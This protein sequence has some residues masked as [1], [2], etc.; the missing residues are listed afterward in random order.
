MQD[1][2]IR[3]LLHEGIAAAKVAQQTPSSTSQIASNQT[4]KLLSDIEEYREQAR[5]L[6]LQVVEQD[7]TNVQA[8]LWL[9]TVV[10]DQNARYTCLSNVLALD[11]DNKQAK[12]GLA[13]LERQRPTTQPKIKRLIPSSHPQKEN[14]KPAISEEYTDPYS[15][16]PDFPTQETKPQSNCP[17]C[18]KPISSSDMTCRHCELPLVMNCPSCNTLMDV[19]WET[20]TECGYTMGDYRLGSVYFTHLAVGYRQHRQIKKALETLQIAE[21]MN[22]DQPDLY[23]LLGEL[24]HEVGYIQE[25]I[26]TLELAIEKEPEQVGPYLSLGRVLKHE[27]HW[28]QAEE[29]YQEVLLMAPDSS[30]AHY[31][32]GDLM[33]QRGQL[34]KARKYLNQAL[35]LDPEHGSAWVQLGQMY[36]SSRKYSSAIRAYRRAVTLLLP[37]SLELERVQDRLQIL[38]PSWQKGSAKSWTSKL[39]ELF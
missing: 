27:G 28:R 1:R 11:P 37:D 38:D 35:K 21:K 32:L 4:Q 9:S 23:R 12:A 20:C 30:E 14:D 19:E 3:R 31:A 18:H 39:K 25:A 8:W 26:D 29:L 24:Q 10:D 6:L 34:K 33:V 36:E 16:Q 7:H 17:F 15:H 2:E 13:W 22:P 5:E